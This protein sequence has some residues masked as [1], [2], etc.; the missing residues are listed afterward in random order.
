LIHEY[1]APTGPEGFT[2]DSRSQRALGCR[3]VER[4]MP[5]PEDQAVR[6][7]YDELMTLGLCH[8][9]KIEFVMLQ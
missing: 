2:D 7:I 4:P 6:R 8:N 1:P 9:V 5:E 3:S